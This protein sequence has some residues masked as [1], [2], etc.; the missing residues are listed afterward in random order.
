[1]LPATDPVKSGGVGAVLVSLLDHTYT[2]PYRGGSP[3]LVPS[4]PGG[5]VRWHQTEAEALMAKLGGLAVG[6]PLPYHLMGP[7]PTDTPLGE[8]PS[9]SRQIV[10]SQ[11]SLT[12]AGASQRPSASQAPG[13]TQASATQAHGSAS[14]S[15]TQRRLANRASLGSQGASQ[16]G[17]Q[18]EDDLS[19]VA[20]VQRIQ[21]SALKVGVPLR[22][23]DV[24][25]T[26]V[27]AL[28]CPV[29]TLELSIN[30]PFPILA[31]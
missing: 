26:V 28:G 14:L 30:R 6:L 4:Y 17:S 7:A 31:G 5:P 19:F 22:A 24:P 3:G 8:R 16:G 1:M 12:L 27:L 15:A 13:A 9:L 20:H 2:L 29:N 10:G 18:S 23:H 11:Y 25:G 21:E